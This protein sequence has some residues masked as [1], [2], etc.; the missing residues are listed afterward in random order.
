MA[1]RAE[2][3]RAYAQNAAAGSNPTLR[4][5]AAIFI[6]FVVALAVVF[7]WPVCDASGPSSSVALDPPESVACA[8]VVEGGE[9]APFSPCPCPCPC[10][11]ALRLQ[12]WRPAP[13]DAGTLGSLKNVALPFL[14][15]HDHCA[16]PPFFKF[17]LFSGCRI[18]LLPAP[19]CAGHTDGAGGVLS[20]R[21]AAAE[22][23]IGVD[24]EVDGTAASSTSLSTTTTGVPEACVSSFARP[25]NPK[26]PTRA[27]GVVRVR[28][29]DTSRPTSTIAPPPPSASLSTSL[30]IVQTR[31]SINTPALLNGDS[32]DIP[33]PPPPPPPIS[34][35]APGDTPIDLG[36]PRPSGDNGVP[37]PGSG[38]A[39]RLAPLAAFFVVAAAAVVFFGFRPRPRSTDSADAESADG[40]GDVTTPTP[41]SRSG[42]A[43][44]DAKDVSAPPPFI[45]PPNPSLELAVCPA[46][47][48]RER[49]ARRGW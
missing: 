39:L 21:R 27:A 30:V 41:A 16:T 31:R 1:K 46:V 26:Y 42:E 35:S 36:T 24:V 32:G 45:P 18:I 6:A 33:P 5:L 11:C 2:R 25:P 3:S 47:R 13:E 48:E 23:G 43:Y 29:L 10:P 4:L 9:S 20:A 14:D 34:S 8:T 40:A 38:D 28:P 15:D 49:G 17:L 44:A 37:R 12:P 19:G 22:T 7:T